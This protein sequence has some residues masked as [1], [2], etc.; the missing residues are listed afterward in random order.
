M[1]KGEESCLEQEELIEADRSHHVGD[2]LA[3][4]MMSQQR[5]TQQCSILLGK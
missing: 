2:S 5:D 1:R 3:I 4:F